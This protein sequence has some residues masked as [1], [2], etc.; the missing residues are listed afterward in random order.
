MKNKFLILLLSLLLVSTS[1]FFLTACGHEHKFNNGKCV[2]CNASIY[3]GEYKE[4]QASEFKD[5]EKKLTEQGRMVDWASGVAYS[6]SLVNEHEELPDVLFVTNLTTTINA[7]KINGE[8]VAYATNTTMQKSK[9]ET[10]NQ[11]DKAYFQNGTSYVQTKIGD[12]ET[13]QKQA[14]TFEQFLSM[15][16]FSLV[17]QMIDVSYVVQLL[18]TGGY[19]SNVKFYKE[20][21][22]NLTK[23]KFVVPEQETDGQRQSLT[24]IYVYDKENKIV[25]F[26]AENSGYNV[27]AKVS[28]IVKFSLSLSNDAVPTV[29]NPQDDTCTSHDFVNMVCR[30]CQAH[31]VDE[32][33]SLS[34]EQ[35]D[36]IE[37]QEIVDRIK[38]NSTLGELS[39]AKNGALIKT[40]KQDTVESVNYIT[41]KTSK[42]WQEGGT[43]YATISVSIAPTDTATA[44]EGISIT[45]NAYVVDKIIYSI[46]PNELNALQEI[47][48]CTNDKY[49]GILELEIKASACTSHG[50]IHD[51]GMFDLRVAY[52]QLYSQLY[53]DYYVGNYGST[54]IVKVYMNDPYMGLVDMYYVYDSDFDLIGAKV[55][56]QCG[57]TQIDITIKPL[58]ESVT[59]PTEVTQKINEYLQQNA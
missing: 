30:L 3:D 48:D 35:V 53:C 14:M 24:L 47:T 40:T 32:L 11:S 1:A 4:I 10:V 54:T 18:T 37:I 16:G 52:E 31:M 8:M 22:S 26:S 41:E 46:Q 21:D 38:N 2:D 44:G 43:D 34:L 28:T 15:Q 12:A 42:V 5:F 17:E 33:D 9:T 6:F 27:T 36:G 51:Y 19:Y 57:Q 45:H 13:K 20:E 58:T 29:S 56:S 7:K 59:I 23:I 50:Y 39:F 25:S 55:I 49:N